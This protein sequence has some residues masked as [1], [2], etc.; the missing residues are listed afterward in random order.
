M[1]AGVTL[2]NLAVAYAHTG[3][4]PKLWRFSARPS[5]SFAS[6]TIAGCSQVASNAGVTYDNLGEYQ[7][8]LESHQHSLALKRELERA[9]ARQS[10]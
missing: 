5:R 2:N 7:A 1:R 9:G 3:E 6:F 8:A 4:K 10:P